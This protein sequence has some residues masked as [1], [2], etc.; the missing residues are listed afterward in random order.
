M[1]VMRMRYSD[2]CR[3]VSALCV[4]AMVLTGCVCG[5]RRTKKAL[6]E[7]ARDSKEEIADAGVLDPRYRVEPVRA[8]AQINPLRDFGVRGVVTFTQTQGG[9]RV[10]ADLV[11]L[12]PGKHGFH[13]HELGVCQ[14]DGSSAGGHFNPTGAPHGGPNTPN[15]HFGDLGNLEADQNGHAHYDAVLSSLALSGAHSIIG[16]SLIVHHDA[17]DLKTQPTGASGGRIACGIIRG[18]GAE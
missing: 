13:I 2:L 16:R 5:E 9:V 15:H 14:A 18:V 1:K 7:K 3:Y 11:G 8:E 12:T 6:E 10:V 4:G 17:D